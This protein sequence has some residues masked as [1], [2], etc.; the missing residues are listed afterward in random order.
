MVMF[1]RLIADIRHAAAAVP[2]EG[3]GDGVSSLLLLHE[4]KRLV[5][6]L[7]QPSDI[8]TKVAID[9]VSRSF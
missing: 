2:R 6:A 3:Q 9:Q 5:N 1:T 8:V 4:A 7:E